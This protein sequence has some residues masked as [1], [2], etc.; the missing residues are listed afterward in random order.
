VHEG[1]AIND[2]NKRRLTFSTGNKRAKGA[3]SKG[4]RQGRDKQA[5]AA[6]GREYS[7]RLLLGG[8]Y[9]SYPFLDSQPNFMTVP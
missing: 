2:D 1:T 6:D 3:D 7:I 5:C 9:S 4:Q 8:G